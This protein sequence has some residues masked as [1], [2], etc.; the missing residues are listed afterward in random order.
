[1]SSV[2]DGANFKFDVEDYIYS[3]RDEIWRAKDALDEIDAKIKELDA[4]PLSSKV[5]FYGKFKR[6]REYLLYQRE[7]AQKRYNDLNDELNFYRKHGLDVSNVEDKERYK[8]FIE[9][10]TNKL[11]IVNMIEV[12]MM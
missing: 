9:I 5:F 3:C 11:N 1:M 2:F 10:R 8:Y 12:G 7:E 4:E 6:K